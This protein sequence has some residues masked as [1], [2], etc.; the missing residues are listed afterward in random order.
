MN[1]LTPEQLSAHLDGALSAEDLR[2]A[3]AHLETC[4][5]CREARAE[6]AASDAALAHTLAHDPGD[7]YF[8]SFAARVAARI[9]G[10]AAGGVATAAAPAAPAPKR[11]R[12]EAPPWYDIGSWFRSPARLAWAGGVAALIV[13][14]GVV[15]MV[16]RETGAPDLRDPEVLGR[17]AQ[18]APAPQ[19]AAP[20]PETGAER[21]E[22]L[23]T[24]AADG[25]AATEG[26]AVALEEQAGR[27]AAPGR[28]RE[29]RRVPGGE[30][31]PAGPSP[32]PAFARPPDEPAPAASGESVTVRRPRLAR[33]LASGQSAEGEKEES[34][35]RQTMAKAAPAPAQETKAT[36][37]ALTRDARGDGTTFGAPKN[38]SACGT[39]VD[40]RG[41]PVANAQVVLADRGVTATTDASGRFCFAVA[42]GAYDISVYAV[43]FAPN[44]Q[45]L[46]LG[47]AEEARIA[48]RT[49]EVLPPPPGASAPSLALTP[50]DSAASF[51]Y[52]PPPSPPPPPMP[53]SVR[54]LWDRAERLTAEAQEE[55]SATRLDVAA[56]AWNGVIAGLAPGT[57]EIMARE[58]L[59][60]A[61]VLAWELRPDGPRT[62]AARKALEN[63][64]ARS[65][66]GPGRDWARAALRRLGP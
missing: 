3:D 30:D 26:G 59:A 62:L 19:A 4:A 1:H 20:V 11:G 66:V 6:L 56:A 55:R 54:A 36:A 41:V 33:P 2:R 60:Q 15:L 13:G 61:R 35:Q 34:A 44:R 53:D 18:T 48:V 43:G 47:G 52:L 10:E 64:L 58:R 51:P 14:A 37:D 5:A 65:P 24:D 25:D 12:H 29:M 50:R 63:Y 40:V 16:S 21:S 42:P 8:E 23:R 9:E 28:A 7:A 22:A 46:E 32:V 38:A 31:V 57:A 45:R 49:V 17:S 27:V 39:V